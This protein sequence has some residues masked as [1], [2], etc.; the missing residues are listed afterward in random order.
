MTSRLLVLPVLLGLVF[1]PGVSA[2]STGGPDGPGQTSWH[3]PLLPPCTTPPCI[4][5]GAISCM[6]QSKSLVIGAFMNPVSLRFDVFNADE[7]CTNVERDVIATVSIESK[8]TGSVIND[9]ELTPPWAP[10]AV[11]AW[12]MIVPASSTIRGELLVDFQIPPV[13]G[14]YVVRIDLTPAPGSAAFPTKT[15]RARLCVGGVSRIRIPQP[16]GMNVSEVNNCNFAGDTV[17]KRF[18][19]D[20]LINEPRTI[21]YVI[22]CTQ[23]TSSSPSDPGGHRDHFPIAEC[24]TT[25]VGDPHSTQIPTMVGTVNLGPNE[26][27]EVCFWVKSFAGCQGGSM[28]EIDVIATDVTP[29]P[30]MT[31]AG[32]VCCARMNYLVIKPGWFGCERGPDATAVMPGPDQAPG[33]W[34][35]L[36][37]I[38]VWSPLYGSLVPVGTQFVA[39]LL[40]GVP[41]SVPHSQSMPTL[42]VGADLDTWYGQPLPM[43]LGP[44][45]APGMHL[46]VGPDHFFGPTP[47]TGNH[48]AECAF[49]VPDDPAL[50]GRTVRVQW[51]MLDAQANTLGLVLSPAARIWLTHGLD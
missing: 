39:V 21:D 42:M 51:A 30:V 16:D 32:S 5:T 46:M 41:T 24:G 18:F 4:A 25:P 15:C 1:T 7:E 44:G 8:P 17:E 35:A 29:N 31:P 28:S 20:N 26:S 23:A 50:V 48:Y 43:D 19:I 6:V 3:P 9:L 33:S 49:S 36:P 27:L 22:T 34:G 13:P 10:H 14:T 11:S 2:L 45:G 37:R 38:A 12:R 40:E 47:P